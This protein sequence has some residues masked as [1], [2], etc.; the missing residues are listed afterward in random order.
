MAIA[1]A[2]LLIVNGVWN[3]AVWPPFLRRVR[4]DPRAHDTAG[5]AT[6][7]LIV[8]AVLIGIS[9]LLGAASLVIGIVALFV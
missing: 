1:L 5:K 6:R 2:I 9:L 8:H 3:L 4:K 7:F